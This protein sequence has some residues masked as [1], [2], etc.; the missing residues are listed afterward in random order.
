MAND[1]GVLIHFNRL[2][3]LMEKYPQATGRGIRATALE[4]ERIV[5][6]AMADSPATG[7]RYGS[8]IS[9]SEGNAPRIDTSN[10]VN[11]INARKLRAFL[12]V[13][14]SGAEYSAILEY[15]GATRPAFPFMGPMAME[16]Q[17]RMPAIVK[18]FLED[19]T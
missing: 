11:N 14:R 6:Q 15:G 7:N 2:P 5:K 4:G 19:V 1:A 18:G 9:A 17:R 8:H 12:W 10:L 16:L 3:E 13:I